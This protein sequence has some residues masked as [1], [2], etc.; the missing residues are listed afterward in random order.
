MLEVVRLLLER[1]AHIDVEGG[2][3][4]TAY[5]ITL[6]GVQAEIARLL[7]WCREKNVG[8]GPL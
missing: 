3:L 8:F 5:Q 6:K 7:S 2:E 4:T 1:G